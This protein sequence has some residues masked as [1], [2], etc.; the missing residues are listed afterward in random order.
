MNDPE[1]TE[2]AC[3]KRAH[4]RG[5]CHMHYSRAR[6]LERGVARPEQ[7]QQVDPVEKILSRCEIGLCWTWSRGAND[8]G[9]GL[10]SWQGRVWYVHRLLWTL[11][12]GP[13]AE[14]LEVDH[15]CKN[16]RCCNPDHLEP[17]TPRVNKLRSGGMSGRH[18]RRDACTNGH[19]YTNDSLYIDRGSGGCRVCDR[20]RNT[21]AEARRA[22]KEA[23]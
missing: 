22:D 9:Y 10:I 18:A 23:R 8:A 12:V 4:A 1:C 17:V 14:G 13:I 16:T 19:P 6:R 2:K 15:L 11:L 3:G 20:T 7:N 21:R 5:L